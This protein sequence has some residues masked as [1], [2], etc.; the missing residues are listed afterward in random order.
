MKKIYKS[1]LFAIIAAAGFTACSDYEAPDITTESAIT[2]TGHETSFPA[3]ASTGSITFEAKGLVTVT[4]NNEWITA[5]VDGNRIDIAVDQNNDFSG[6]SGSI[7][8][9]CGNATDNISIIQSGIIFKYDDVST[10]DI[11]SDAWSQSYKAEATLP[12]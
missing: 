1:V 2:I 12:V 6:R 9:K 8:V 3:S 7:S 10:I 11:D 5:S 4:A